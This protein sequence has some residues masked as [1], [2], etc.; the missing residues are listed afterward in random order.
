M[1][2][3]K[4]LV[5]A[6]CLLLVSA[7]LV[8]TSTYAWFS[9]NTQV[10]AT[11]MQVKAQAEGGIVISNEAKTAWN[12]SATASHNAVAELIP[13]STADATAWYHAVSD[14][15]NNAKAGQDANKYTT[16]TIEETNGVGSAT[17]GTEDKNVYLLNK[18]YIQ[19]SADAIDLTGKTPA[20]LLINEVIVSGVGTSTTLD[21][22]LRIMIKIGST[23]VIYAPVTG[24][25][26]SYKVAASESSTVCK[27][28]D[29]N[30]AT[31]VTTIPAYTAA[32]TNA[33]EASVY[34]YFEGEDA[35]CK[36]A[37]I[38]ATLDTLQVT[39]RFGTT[40]IE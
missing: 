36:S 25:T 12:A 29:K 16:L 19:S 35:N 32:G 40:A 39:V 7:M 10:T 4:K 31:S 18:F 2:N 17:V 28:T 24:A 26:I 22:S 21:A 37:N 13:T 1:K 33:L 6:L 14:D 30:V 34:V 11:G 9:M 23:T 8:G 15:A 20:N 3:F 5:P 38:T 27:T